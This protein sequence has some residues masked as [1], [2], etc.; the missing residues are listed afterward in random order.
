M[1]IMI[2]PGLATPINYS[3]IDVSPK[4]ALWA[5]QIF[6]PTGLHPANTTCK[7]LLAYL[8]R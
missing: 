7:W 8:T 1:E 5:G 2:A 4:G 6:N 3:E